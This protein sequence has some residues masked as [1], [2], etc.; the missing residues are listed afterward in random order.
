MSLQS[1]REEVAVAINDYVR[2]FG[3]RGEIKETKEILEFLK[4]KGL[5]LDAMFLVSDMCYNKTNKANLKSFKNDILLFEHVSRGKYYIL[6][7]HYSYTGKVV[8]TDKHG[9]NHDVGEW[10]EGKLSYWGDTGH[11]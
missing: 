1:C 5:K 2:E 3:A 6:G 7:E 9:F 4:T 10:K 11:V 8:W